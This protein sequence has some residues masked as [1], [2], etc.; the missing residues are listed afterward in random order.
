[1]LSFLPSVLALQPFP[2]PGG[3]RSSAASSTAQPQSVRVPTPPQPLV[4]QQQ[5][6]GAARWRDVDPWHPA[7]RRAGENLIRVYTSAEA[8]M[9]YRTAEIVEAADASI[10]GLFEFEHKRAASC[11]NAAQTSYWNDPR[12]HNF[13]NC[14]WRGLLH[15]LVVPIATHAIDRFAYGGIDVRK[16]IHETLI[17]DNYDVVDLGC[18]VGFSPARNGRVTGVDSS[19]QMLTVARMR[20]PDVSFERGNSETWGASGCCDMA[21]IMYNMHEMPS[22][23]RLR[24]LLN[25]QRIARRSVMVVDIWPGFKPTA[26]MLSGEPYVLDYLENIDAEVKASAGPGWRVQRVDIVPEHVTMWRLD[27]ED[28]DEEQA[29]RDQELGGEGGLEWGI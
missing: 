15:A 26:M 5:T 24:V 4:V 22:K 21:T 25:A 14:G 8:Y 19:E 10:A 16:Q 29:G 7:A 9:E 23:A 11:P 18:G 17:P 28:G 3:P 13:G 1:M 6:V 20:R 2:T 27:R 12:I